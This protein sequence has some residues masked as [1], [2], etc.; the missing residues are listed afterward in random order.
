MG[1]IVRSITF[2]TFNASK[3]PNPALQ[4]HYR[5]LQAI[6]LD[7][8][9]PEQPE[10]KTL[11]KYSSIHK[12]VGPLALEWGEILDKDAP[13]GRFEPPKKRKAVTNEKEDGPAEKKIK[14]EKRHARPTS[15][16]KVESL[17]EQG[18]L[19]TVSQFLKNSDI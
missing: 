13:A 1:E 6:A 7:E 11:P 19:M 9:L 12:R 8:E 5:I 3:Y 18:S 2:K 15:G 10:D 16:D 14:T 4:W 17:Y